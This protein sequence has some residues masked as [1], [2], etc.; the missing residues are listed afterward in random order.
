[1]RIDFLVDGTRRYTFES[2]EEAASYF[3]TTFAWNLEADAMRRKRYAAGDYE[4]PEWKRAAQELGGL[5]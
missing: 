2:E 5:N 3:L 1:M 4:E